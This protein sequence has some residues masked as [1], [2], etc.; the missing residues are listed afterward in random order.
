MADYPT[1]KKEYEKLKNKHPLPRFEEFTLVFGFPKEDEVKSVL[2]L[3]RAV[4]KTPFNVSHWIM[5]IL[6]PHDTITSH[7]S[8]V[9]KDLRDDLLSA[10]KKCVIVDKEMSLCSFNASQAK[11]PEKLMA[12][13]I[14]AASAELKE[15]AEFLKKVLEKT[16]D[17]WRNAEDEK[18]STYHW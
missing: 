10:M 7:D 15:V 1:I 18:E 2:T 14:A 6:S 17:G 16:A 11:D 3:F 13:S 4:K 8:Q 9:T 5:D 12:E